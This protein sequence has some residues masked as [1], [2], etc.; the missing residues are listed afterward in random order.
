MRLP[1]PPSATRMLIIR[2]ATEYRLISE[3]QDTARSEWPELLLNVMVTSG[4]EL[5]LRAIPGS[6]GSAT[7]IGPAGDSEGTGLVE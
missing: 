1:L 3:G 2:L 4:P 5:Q 7:A 6:V